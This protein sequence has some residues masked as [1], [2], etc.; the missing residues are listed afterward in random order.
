M[1][2]VS[3]P[4]DLTALRARLRALECGGRAPTLRPTGLAGIDAH[5]PGG[6]LPIA[7]LHHVGGEPGPATALALR[8]ADR[9]TLPERALGPLVWIA[10]VLEPF[11]PGLAGQAVAA[12]R[13]LLVRALH[14]ADR[15]WAFEEALRTPGVAATVSRMVCHWSIERRR[16]LG[17]C[18]AASSTMSGP[19]CSGRATSS[20]G[21]STTWAWLVSTRRR[22]F[23]CTALSSEVSFEALVATLIDEATMETAE[24]GGASATAERL[25]QVKAGF[26]QGRVLA[27]ARLAPR[28][29]P[30]AG[31]PAPAPGWR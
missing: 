18:S 1:T 20:G 12:S 19:L 8:F 26:A 9:L 2:Q 3:P 31:A 23:A 16:R 7:C 4:L 27:S 10:A 11:G 14:P 6:G 29:C 25:A 28:P 24:P 21:N 30:R 17:R 13:L 5:F 22:K 15:V